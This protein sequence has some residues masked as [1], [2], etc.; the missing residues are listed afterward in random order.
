MRSTLLED[1][2]DARFFAH[3]AAAHELD[4]H[5]RA[6]GDPL[7]VIANAV[8]QRL[9]KPRVVENPNA[10]SVEERGHAGRVRKTGQR[11]VNDHPVPAGEHAED[12]ALMALDEIA[13]H[14]TTMSRTLGATQAA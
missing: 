11:A 7:G 8:P 12:L 5:A 10:A 14:P 1:L 2:F 4:L 6:R 3:L 13:V 9:G